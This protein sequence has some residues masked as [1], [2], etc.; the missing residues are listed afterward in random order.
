MGYCI[1]Y[2]ILKYVPEILGVFN[3]QFEGDSGSDVA[4]DN[5]ESRG[6]NAEE[7]GVAGGGGDSSFSEMKTDELPR[8]SGDSGGLDDTSDLS[9]GK[10]GKHILEDDA[11]QYEPKLMAQAVRTMMAQDE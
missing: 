4:D 5:A 2:I 8:M 6:L 11:M 10:F 1:G 7:I 3:I 9:E